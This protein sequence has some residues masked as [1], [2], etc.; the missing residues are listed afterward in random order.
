MRIP[1]E[2][3]RGGKNSKKRA[4]VAVARKLA[5]LLYWLWVS[6]PSKLLQITIRKFP[7]ARTA[8]APCGFGFQFFEV[9]IQSTTLFHC[10]DL[11]QLCGPSGQRAEETSPQ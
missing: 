2:K 9:R 11:G 1:T 5:V 4:I 7:R 10:A 8:H 6:S 3:P